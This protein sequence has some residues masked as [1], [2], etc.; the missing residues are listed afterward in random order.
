MKFI[1]LGV[2]ACYQLKL[3]Q[4]NSGSGSNLSPILTPAPT[5]LLFWNLT[6]AP[7]FRQFWLLFRQKKKAWSGSETL[8]PT[9]YYNWNRQHIFINFFS[10]YFGKI[11][12]SIIYY[13]FIS[14][15]YVCS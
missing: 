14:F 1:S 4:I 11:V 13:E 5:L 6:P 7:T 15:A 2:R 12:E 9:E 8:Q 3:E 10:I